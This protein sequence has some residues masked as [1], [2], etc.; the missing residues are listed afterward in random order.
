MPQHISNL[1]HTAITFIYFVSGSP[2]RLRYLK[3]RTHLSIPIG[4]NGAWHIVFNKY[5]LNEWIDG[6]MNKE[7]EV[8]YEHLFNN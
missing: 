2:T 7:W 3:A 1:Y 8:I 4:L 6:W 5:L